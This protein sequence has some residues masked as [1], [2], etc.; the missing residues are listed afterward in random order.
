MPAML[1]PVSSMILPRNW[2]GAGVEGGVSVWSSA[3]VACAGG[4]V[5][6][7][8]TAG[9]EGGVF[10]ASRTGVMEEDVE[11]ARLAK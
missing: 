6:F 2:G 9:E 10:G 5:P 3:R 1:A 11:G 7:P 8:V 4:T